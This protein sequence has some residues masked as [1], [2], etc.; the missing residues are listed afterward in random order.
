MYSAVFLVPKKFRLRTE[1]GQKKDRY[2]QPFVTNS[3]PLF[4]KSKMVTV[5]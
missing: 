4:L 2:G 1:I 5:G 3:F